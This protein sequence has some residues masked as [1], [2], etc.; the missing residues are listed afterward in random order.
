LLSL[1]RPSFRT[2]QAG[3]EAAYLGNPDFRRQQYGLVVTNIPLIYNSTMTVQ[4]GYQRHLSGACGD[5][6]ARSLLRG[7]SGGT[8]P[9]GTE[10]EP[11]SAP[12]RLAHRPGPRRLTLPD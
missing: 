12:F 3:P 10:D 6:L 11:D 2:K 1:P 5:V 8:L 9:L 7:G 4:E